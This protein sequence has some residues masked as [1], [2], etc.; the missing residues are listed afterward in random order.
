MT[1]LGHLWRHHRTALLA[2]A[3]A[4]LITLF[5]AIRFTASA[6]YWSDPAH[7]DLA[8]QGWMTPGFV[9]RSW[10]IPRD[11]IA[12]MLGLS[13]DAKRGQTLAEIAAAR[14]EP[15]ETFLTGLAAALAAAR[16]DR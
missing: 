2:F 10:D 11:E 6:I 7:R 8:P 3:A 13:T 1:G 15:V 16:T 14:D 12:G 5:F 9:A 4:L